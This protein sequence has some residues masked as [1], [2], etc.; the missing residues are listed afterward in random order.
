[1]I[2]GEPVGRTEAVVDFAAGELQ[3]RIGA[4]HGEDFIGVQT[5]STSGRHGIGPFEHGLRRRHLGLEIARQ[6]HAWLVGHALL[7][8]RRDRKTQHM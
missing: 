1:M 2:L 7:R 3:R 5:R 4:L 6:R 8:Q